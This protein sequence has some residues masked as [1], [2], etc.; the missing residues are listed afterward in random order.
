MEK[1]Q[2]LVNEIKSTISQKTSSNKDEVKIMRA[3]MNDTEYKV[4]VYAKNGMIGEYCPA[5][6]AR[7]MAAS[8][9]H[10]AAGLTEK[11]ST[12]LAN[13][14]TFGK[15]EAKCVVE[16]SKEF[17][18]TYMHTGRKIALGGRATSDISIGIKEIESSERPFPKVV[19]IGDDGKKIYGRGVTKV[20]AYDSIKVYS[21]CPAWIK[22]NS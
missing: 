20:G 3:M 12:V 19:G 6:S 8:I 10:G 11:E 9:L 2:E 18:N 4:G 16:L 22:E 21:P 13:N 1:V 15:S 17:I 5:D 7:E 14:Y